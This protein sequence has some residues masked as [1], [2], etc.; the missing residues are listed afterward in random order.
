M[1]KKS[2]ILVFF[3]HQN[4]KIKK[5]RHPQEKNVSL[6]MLYKD[7]LKEQ[8]VGNTC[9]LSGLDPFTSCK[10]LMDTSTSSV[11]TFSGVM[12]VWDW[13]EGVWSRTSEFVQ[14]SGR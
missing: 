8:T 11:Y 13:V 4:K 1:R 14:D 12:K 7:L 5:L 2:M 3:E 6:H 10:W 9:P